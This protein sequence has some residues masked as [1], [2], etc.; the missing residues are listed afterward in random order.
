MRT[1]W[2][3]EVTDAKGSAMSPSFMPPVVDVEDTLRA[4]ILC[5]NLITYISD[6]Y[7]K[8][9]DKLAIWLLVKNVIRFD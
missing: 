3:E 8:G 5:G 6:G 7:F 2:H 1:W 9:F 4:L